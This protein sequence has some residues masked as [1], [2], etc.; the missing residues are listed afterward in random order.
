MRLTQRQQARI[1]ENQ[2]RRHARAERETDGGD[3]S[4][5]LEQTGVVM[6]HQGRLLV[7]EDTQGQLY[8]CTARRH[9]GALV[10]GDRVVWQASGTHSGVIVARS[11]RRSL[12][13]RDY[14]GQP[15]PIAANLD[16]VAVVLAPTPAPDEALIDR[17]LVAIAAMDVRGLLL[18][19]KLDSLDAVAREAWRARLEPYQQAGY[20]A[21]GVSSH[22]GEGLALLREWLQG[23]TSLLAGQSGVGKSSLVQ[24]LLPDCAIRIQAVSALTGHGAHTTSVSTLY[25]LPEGGDLLDTP[26][27]RGFELGRMSLEALDRG[28]GDLAPYFGHCR[29][30][31]C[32]HTVEPDCALQAAA[33]RGEIAP[34]RLASYCQLRAELEAAA[35]PGRQSSS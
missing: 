9:L 21:L 30:S 31:G 2:Q 11:P 28:F 8:A 5:A 27:V 26:G 14:Q 6:S 20:P 23:R 17:Y 15:R 10:C 25:H 3:A 13:I 33:E 18:L 4:A 34:R 12:L 1:A 7:V 29:F 22:T 16:A 35:R 24:A 32:R 19:N